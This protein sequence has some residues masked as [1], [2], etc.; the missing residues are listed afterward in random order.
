MPRAGVSKGRICGCWHE[1]GDTSQITSNTWQITHDMWHL[2]HDKIS[3]VQ[4]MFVSFRFCMF[5]YVSVRFCMFLYVFVCFCP[6]LYVHLGIFFGF[7]AIIR[8]NWAIQRLLYSDSLWLHCYSDYINVKNANFASLNTNYI[9]KTRIAV[10]SD[11][12]LA[13]H[14]L[15]TIV[16]PACR[17]F[18]GQKVMFK[19]WSF[20]PTA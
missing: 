18:S 17:R 2:T 4:N 15:T 14:D 3:Y 19:F 11:K 16:Y 6:F 1:T 9:S 5:L 7:G 12:K 13:T 20:V 8:T 10:L